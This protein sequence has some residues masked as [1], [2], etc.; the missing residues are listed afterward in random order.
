MPFL[1]LILLAAISLIITL[2]GYLFTSTTQPRTR[3]QQTAHHVHS[4][5]NQSR[6]RV[7]RELPGTRREVV[8]PEYRSSGGR[9]P[10]ATHRVVAFT[11]QSTWVNVWQSLFIIPL[12]RQRRRGE[13]TP[14]IGI[15]LVL[16][17][18]FLLGLFLLRTLMPNATLIGAVMWPSTL[19][20]SQSRANA[21]EP[22][23][24]A[25]QALVRIS[26]LD[27]AQYG[28]SHEY[29]L[30]AYSAC[31]AAAMTEVFN[32]YGRH[33]RVTDVLKIEAHIGEITPQLGLLEGAGIERTATQFGFKTSW[34]HNL[35]LD[36][37]IDIANHG[38][39]VIVSF[40][41]DR[42][43]G[44]HILV[45]TGGNRQYVYLADTS[46]WNRHSLTR[47]QFMQWW[48]GYTAIVTPN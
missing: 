13:P 47:E 30:W 34:G 38:R 27:P 15:G 23:Y 4:Y 20:S 3:N 8:H 37:M 16:L 35:S 46:R 39:P 25:S 32:A 9:E 40:P 2:V 45:V 21:P 29:D 18:V 14:W 48:E 26:Q 28:S 1:L 44:G 19:N 12:F 43:D 11:E 24:T 22:I 10:A 31:S 33:F 5:G 36:T 42:Y 7:V 6:R 41:P 17:S